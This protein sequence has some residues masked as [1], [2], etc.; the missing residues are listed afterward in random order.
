M[1]PSGVG[2]LMDKME[3]LAKIS[4]KLQK[5]VQ[6]QK[7]T[8][9]TED[10]EEKE[11]K[12]WIEK[13]KKNPPDVKLSHQC[14]KCKGFG[15]YYHECPTERVLSVMEVE[16]YKLFNKFV[17]S[18]ELSLE[19]ASAIVENVQGEQEV[20]VQ[21][22]TTTP[23][24]QETL[25]SSIQEH[26]HESSVVTFVQDCDNDLDYSTSDGKHEESNE[27]RCE[28]SISVCPTQ[29][30]VQK[31]LIEEWIDN[32]TQP[33]EN[34]CQSFFRFSNS[35][36]DCEAPKA[37]QVGLKRRCVEVSNGVKRGKHDG[38]LMYLLDEDNSFSRGRE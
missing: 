11:N 14:F 38:V 15:H 1:K 23:L 31:P 33:K 37:M 8:S 2:Y 26:E 18:D 17:N 35:C 6:P 7:H 32:K 13:F 16:E 22:V 27:Q 25:Q 3:N 9:E 21:G 4:A 19:D 24:E 28:T 5:L 36:F 34:A 20:A 30:E 10:K 29:K 12:R